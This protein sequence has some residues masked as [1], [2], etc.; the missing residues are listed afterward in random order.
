MPKA[1]SAYAEKLLDPRWQKRRLEIMGRDEFTCQMC[2]DSES[3][4]MV[5]HRYY[6]WGRDPW[7]YPDEMLIT[8]CGGCHESEHDYKDSAD[9][10]VKILKCEGFFNGEISELSEAFAKHS[11]IYPPGVLVSAICRMI[12]TRERQNVFFDNYFTEIRAENLAKAEAA[13]G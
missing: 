7:E 2:G 12:S 6:A 13:N 4:L 10:L 11:P 3:T 1:K 8:L 9:D 5:H